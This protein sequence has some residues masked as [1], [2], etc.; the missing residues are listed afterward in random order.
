MAQ[1]EKGQQGQKKSGEQEKEQAL[2]LHVP[3]SPTGEKEPESNFPVVALGASAGGLEAFQ[4]FFTHLP[5][6]T[7]MAFVLIQHLDPHHKS[8]LSDLLKGYT[9]MKVTEVEDG[10]MLQPDT[11]FVIPPNRYL[12]VHY[13]KLHLLAPT[14]PCGPRMPIDYFFRSLAADRKQKAAC[15]VLSGTGTEGALG[16]KAIKGEGGLVLVQDPQTA[17]Y[18]GMP[19]NALATGL[20]DYS[21][22]PEKMPERLTA[23]F[24]HNLLETP[25]QVLSA[26]PYQTNLL[27]KVLLLIRSRTGHDFTRYKQNTIVRRIERRMAVNQIVRQADYIRF[28]QAYPKEV[29][30]LFKELLIGVTNF[31]RDKDAF[32]VIKETALP[33]LFESHPVNQP[34]RIWVPGCATG[35]EA[36]SLAILC[37]AVM[38]EQKKE[39]V[40]QIFATDIDPAAINSARVGLYHQGI[41]VDVPAP[42]LECYFEGEGNGYR[43][44]KEIRDM[45]VFALQNVLSDPPFSRL[46][47]VSCRNLLIYLGPELQEKV[48]SLFYYALNPQG[49]LFLGSSETPGGLSGYFT[50]VDRKWKVFQ[51]KE[52]IKHFPLQIPVATTVQHSAVAQG[53]PVIS[54]PPPRTLYRNVIEK[55]ILN[56]YS[57]TGVLIDEDKNILFISGRAGKYL[58]PPDGIF[59]GNILAMAREG[60]KLQLANAIHNAATKKTWTCCEKIVVKTNGGE[61]LV[62]LVVKPLAD[63][64]S[65]KG[66]LLVIFRDVA[67]NAAAKE[68][69]KA[70]A[71]Q[72]KTTAASVAQTRIMQL[73]QELQYNK[74]YLQTTVEELYSS[75]EE[76]QST[77]EELQTSKEELQSI[78]EELTT[79]NLEL[80]KKIEELSQVSS[81]LSNL[82]SSTEIGTV[83]LDEE[84]KIRRFTP[85]IVQCINLIPSDIG[86]PISHI[87]SNL[88]NYDRLVVDCRQVLQ[89]LQIKEK[90]VQVSDGN[91]YIMRIL[92]YRTVEQKIDG[93]V[94]AFVDIS[95]R[96]K[97]EAHL[98]ASCTKLEQRVDERTAALSEKKVKLEK[99]VGE[100]R[101][102]EYE[103]AVTL[104]NVESAWEFAG[105]IVETVRE[106]LVVL[107]ESLHVVSANQP[108]YNKFKVTPWQTEK[109]H[110][111]ELGNGQWNI[112]ALRELLGNVLPQKKEF[113]DFRIEH[114]FPEI[115]PKTMLLNGREVFSCKGGKNKKLILLAIE[116]IT[117]RV[118]SP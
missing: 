100:R 103:L 71:Q 43:V 92:P 33:Q 81:D 29:D 42:W 13:G 106:P 21:L 102:A 49:Y 78:N 6:A 54:P 23:Y 118:A 9:D 12:A 93:V 66:L 61:Q 22:P 40:V 94:V 18:D 115:G 34:V 85:A 63:P 98:R 90:E 4:L 31:F 24:N 52:M 16:L 45:V 75:N 47:M 46:D 3:V 15:I 111:F 26:C 89:T 20:A 99:E 69:E 110:I 37:R 97:Y 70:G 112:P 88:L 80:E 76:L 7:G 67:E 83:F 14:H 53:V 25:C 11:V 28:L 65:L 74:E 84:L 64:V 77:N 104:K 19:E 95:M 58:E 36:Y 50:A 55:I 44:R 48:L 109:K 72:F 114:N 60:L 107:D 79:V 27:E 17:K 96:K 116:D 32:G 5:P 105:S 108:F 39:R 2:L 35:E 113:N 57:P 73:E 117:G 8:I 30:H 38:L 68:K 82:L 1:G 86:R 56:E 62:D 51:K 91:W 59:T 10:M 87:S 101:R 41:A